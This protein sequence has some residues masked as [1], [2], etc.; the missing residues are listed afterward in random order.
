MLAAQIVDV[1]LFGSMTRY[2]DLALHAI[3]D[4]RRRFTGQELERAAQATI[5]DF[6]VLGCRYQPRFWRD[7]W[8]PLNDPISTMVQVVDPA[9]DLEAETLRW[10]GRR[11][12]VT[13]QRPLRVVSLAAG[14][15]SRLIL[16]FMHLAVDGGGVAAVGH[17]FGS[18]LYGQP[19][20]LAVEARRDLAHALAR[21][22]WYHLP[23]LVRDGVTTLLQPL[24]TAL[25]GPR[26]RP[27]E[28]G[29]GRA[30]SWRHLVVPPEALNDIKARC[31]VRGATI[32]DVLIAA[33]ARVAAQRSSRGPVAV[34]YTMD[35]R[36][37]AAAPKLTAANTS[38]ML[39]ALVPR[40]AI[41]DLSATAAAVARITARQ[42][43]GLLGPAY[44]L[45]P[46]T[47]APGSP[48]GLVRRFVR[49]LH[50]FV[51]DLPLSRGLLVTNVGRIDEG[52]SAFGDDIEAIQVI[53]PNLKGVPVPAVVAFGFRGQLCLEIFAPPEVAPQGLDALE[54]ELRQALELGSQPD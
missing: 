16:S 43:R 20:S 18:H 14:A 4:L 8:V 37:Y 54:A 50:P 23:V 13:R 9:D 24:R 44:V 21:L 36:R 29:S 30:P 53:G 35:L 1:G 26:E 7:R 34:T 41:G 32:N 42:R 39:T 33:M 25:A 2:G 38:A 27:Y 17:V 48:H 51:V 6:P 45:T 22:R 12:D 28:A 3:V 11:I 31:R 15:G 47:M 52:L 5:A 46:M 40:D 49:G 10:V 19:P